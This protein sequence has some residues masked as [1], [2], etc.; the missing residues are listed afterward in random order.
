MDSGVLNPQLNAEVIGPEASALWARSRLRDRIHAVIAHEYEESGGIPHDQ[1][2]DR[3][4]ETT[5]P[6]G[7]NARRVLRSTAKGEKRQR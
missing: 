5:L 1:V 2:V 7:E 6:I 3:V 4:A